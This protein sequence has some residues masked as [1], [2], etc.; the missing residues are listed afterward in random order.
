MKTGRYSVHH[1]PAAQRVSAL[2]LVFLLL[3]GPLSPAG[4]ESAG[5]T[6]D[7]DVVMARNAVYVLGLKGKDGN[8]LLPRKEPDMYGRGE[9]LVYGEEPDYEGVVGYVSLQTSWDVSRFNTFTQVPWQLPAYKPDGDGWQV[10]GAVQ[11]KTP[12]LVVSQKLREEKGHKYAGYL[13]VVRLDTMA[14]TWIDV[15]QFVTVPYWTL[16][17][18]EAVNYGFCIAVYKDRSRYEPMD[19]RKHHGMLP[20][21]LRILMCDTRTARYHSP[22]KERNPMLGI[23]FRSAEARDMY[24]RSFLFF[25]LEDLTLVY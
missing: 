22:D 25:N 14:V 1:R 18:K 7:V 9:P 19:K 10:A 20:E 2:L 6:P 24:Y 5:G 17:L 23:V 11:H 4:A 15:E 13:Q 12:V 8:P 21:G 3:A 16:E